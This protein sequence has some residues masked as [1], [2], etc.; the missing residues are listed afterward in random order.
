MLKLSN[1]EFTFEVGGSLVATDA[2][3]LEPCD[4]V[5]HAK[6]LTELFYSP[7]FLKSPLNP[8]IKANP[9]PISR[10]PKSP[11][12]PPLFFRGDEAMGLG[13][14]GFVLYQVGLYYVVVSHR[15]VTSQANFSS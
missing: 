7:L 8:L 5:I 12:P 4:A 2:M 6:I 14:G 3:F 15:S 1:L 10:D 11:T 13:K 9:P